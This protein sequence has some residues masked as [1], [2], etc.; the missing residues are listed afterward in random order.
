MELEWSVEDQL[1]AEVQRLNEELRQ[2]EKQ[3]SRA[4]HKCKEQKRIISK[5]SRKIKQQDEKMHYLNKPANVRRKGKSIK[6]G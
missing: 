3:L 1:H 2:K 4:R 6:K 5:M